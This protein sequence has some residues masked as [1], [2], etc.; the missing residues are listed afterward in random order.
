LWWSGGDRN[1]YDQKE[2]RRDWCSQNY[3]GLKGGGIETWCWREN[4][5]IL[6]VIGPKGNRNPHR[7]CGEYNGNIEWHNQWPRISVVGDQEETW[8][9]WEIMKS[10]SLLVVGSKMDWQ[11]RRM[12]ATY[13]F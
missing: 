13:K 9:N 11:E 5:G 8:W 4:R 10:I 1:L 2:C 12:G 3:R 7:S 6:E